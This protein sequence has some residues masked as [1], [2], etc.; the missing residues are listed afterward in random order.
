MPGSKPCVV[1]DGHQGDQEKLRPDC[2]L[3]QWCTGVTNQYALSRHVLRQT[4]VYDADHRATLTL[5]GEQCAAMSAASLLCLQTWSMSCSIQ[6]RL[7]GNLRQCRTGVMARCALYQGFSDD[8]AGESSSTRRFHTCGLHATTPRSW[9]AQ[10]MLGE[11]C[12]ACL[13]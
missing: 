2:R 6:A 9:Q 5:W 12:L 7:L 3:T 13:D 11:P 1:H 10:I 8:L 4:S